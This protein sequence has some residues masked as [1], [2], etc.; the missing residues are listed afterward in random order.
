MHDTVTKLLK[1]NNIINSD[2]DQSKDKIEIIIKEVLKLQNTFV[3]LNSSSQWNT[4]AVIKAMK[5]QLE[6]SLGASMS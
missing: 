2:G 3:T 6:A 5:P 4:E 1:Q